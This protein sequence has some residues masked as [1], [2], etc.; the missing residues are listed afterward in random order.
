M[1]A[2]HTIGSVMLETTCN[3]DTA[4]VYRH[5][6]GVW[7]PLQITTRVKDSLSRSADQWNKDPMDIDIPATQY[8]DLPEFAGA[9][10]F[11]VAVCRTMFVRIVDRSSAGSR[12]F[13][14]FGPM[15][16]FRGGEFKWT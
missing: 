4:M 14:R 15:A 16:L 2:G 11:I 12:C 9:C 3:I 1:A 5:G 8:A 6:Y 7:L 13:L 10:I